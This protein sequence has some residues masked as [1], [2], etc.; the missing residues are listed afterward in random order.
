MKLYFAWANENEAF[1]P[2]IHALTDGEILSLS[3]KLFYFELTFTIF[4]Y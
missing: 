3:L 2:D 4:L 1:N